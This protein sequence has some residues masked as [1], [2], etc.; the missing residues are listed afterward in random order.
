M[1]H[2][3]KSCLNMYN[4]ATL[5]VPCRKILLIINYFKNLVIWKLVPQVIYYKCNINFN[6]L[7]TFWKIIPT[8][9]KGFLIIWPW[10]VDWTIFLFFDVNYIKTIEINKSIFFSG[11]GSCWIFL[12]QQPTSSIHHCVCFD[13]IS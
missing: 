13:S 2:E 9:R 1:R 5:Y 11:H 3:Q 12:L 8:L 10:K 6:F 7:Q 4:G